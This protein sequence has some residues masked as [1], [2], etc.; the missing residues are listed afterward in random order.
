MLATRVKVVTLGLLF[1]WSVVLT[2]SALSA[3]EDPPL[4]P[5]VIPPGSTVEEDE[6]KLES[7]EVP[8]DEETAEGIEPVAE[9]PEPIPLGILPDEDEGFIE[10]YDEIP[11]YEMP[12]QMPDEPWDDGDSCGEVAGCYS[13]P[14]CTP[15]GLYWFQADYLMWWTRGSRLPP[16]ITT[17]P[18]GTPAGVLGNA[19]TEIL[20][21]GER[22]NDD[23]QSGYRIT[24]GQWID[25]TATVG[26]EGDYFDLGGN[27]TSFSSGISS[28]D[29]VL[30]RPFYDV[31]N[32]QQSSQ[33]IAYPDRA[34]GEGRVKAWDHFKSA[35]ARMRYN[36][37]NRVSCCES[38]CGVDS[39]EVD[40]CGVDSCDGGPSCYTDCG[41]SSFRLD[42][43]AG[44]RYYQLNGNLEISEE[45]ISLDPRG[46]LAIGTMFDIDE[47]FRASN[48]F[49][50]AELGLEAEFCR[51]PWSLE[52]LAKMALGSNYRTVTINGIT[53]ITVPGQA[54][55]T[56]AGGLLALPTNMG[57]FADDDFSIIPQFGLELGYR[58]SSHVQLHVGYNF[59]YW[60]DVVRAGEQIDLGINPSQ[61]PPGTLSGDARPAFDFVDSDFWAQGLNLGLEVTF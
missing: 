21:G 1:L 26:M 31:V 8:D 36:V 30:A 4:E 40:S 9:E 42:F 18:V 34:A 11:D 43:L 46:P 29:P 58:L 37:C 56:H 2:G 47:V 14:C 59:I 53:E 24:F 10:E 6:L 51:G 13:D 45:V 35:G 61:I 19:T 15:S 39:C 28:G 12:D 5:P 33:L 50:G 44:Y 48:E 57:S 38:S 41:A 32:E 25:C 23:G 60:S 7:I 16:L 3:A 20:F 22:V 54:T 27:T 55:A 17:S 52:V 49:N